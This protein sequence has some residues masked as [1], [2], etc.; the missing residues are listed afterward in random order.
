MPQREARA[1]SGWQGKCN[2]HMCPQVTSK[3]KHKPHQMLILKL[4]PLNLV[5]IKAHLSPLVL[6]LHIQSQLQLQK[7][8]RKI[9]FFTDQQCKHYM[10]I[11]LHLQGT[12]RLMKAVAAE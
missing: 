5:R 7:S 1:L 2:L 12:N 3:E 9:S 10:H 6:L 4:V 11:I 8:V